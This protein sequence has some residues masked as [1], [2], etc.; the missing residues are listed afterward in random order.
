MTFP[1]RPSPA[2]VM[3]LGAD[4]VSPPRHRRTHSPCAPGE[5]PTSPGPQRGPPHSSCTGC[6]GGSDPKR[7]TTCEGL[8]AMCYCRR[9]QSWVDE[10]GSWLSHRTQLLQGLLELAFPSPLPP[11]FLP[12]ILF[13]FLSPSPAPLPLHGKGPNGGPGHSVT[14]SC[15]LDQAMRVDRYVVYL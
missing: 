4:M 8:V 1:N 10:S 5:P 13:P 14:G 12:F 3:C 15:D 6:L 11:R 2:A 9:G 7:K